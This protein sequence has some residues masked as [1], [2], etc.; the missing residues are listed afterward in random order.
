[1]IIVC[2]LAQGRVRLN[3]FSRR[4]F[5][6][7]TRPPRIGLPILIQRIVETLSGPR[8]RG[9]FLNVVQTSPRHMRLLDVVTVIAVLAALAGVWYLEQLDSGSCYWIAIALFLLSKA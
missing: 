9:T 4:A 5:V 7:P 8:G 3:F 2:R 6:P 1:M